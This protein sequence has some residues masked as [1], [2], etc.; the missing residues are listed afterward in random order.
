MCAAFQRWQ[1]TDSHSSSFRL[2]SLIAR[3]VLSGAPVSST[4]ACF[5]P[6]ARSKNEYGEI[7]TDHVM[8]PGAL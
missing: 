3:N 1:V 4:K 8:F 6:T 7:C 2:C 5:L